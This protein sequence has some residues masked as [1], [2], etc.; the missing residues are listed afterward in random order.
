MP[1]NP[2]TDPISLMLTEFRLRKRADGFLNKYSELYVLSLFEDENGQ[3]GDRFNFSTAIFP[4]V[5]VNQAIRPGGSGQLLYGPVNPGAFLAFNL[6]FME[7]DKDIRD[8]GAQ[9]GEVLGSE[10]AKL[11]RK[12]LIAANPGAAATVGA[13]NTIAN[14]VVNQL[15]AN[16]DDEL[17]RYTGTLLRHK[18]YNVNKTLQANP[19]DYIHCRLKALRA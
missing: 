9:V 13:L 14:L 4:K 3:S 1:F 15:K 16:K 19:N 11:L 17:F 8:V 2:E 12:S 18:R 6:I 5:R 10:E 7:S